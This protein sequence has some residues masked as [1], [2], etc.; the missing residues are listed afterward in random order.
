[1]GH[2]ARIRGG[3][4]FAIASLRVVDEQIWGKKIHASR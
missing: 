2:T 4:G 3:I 1:M